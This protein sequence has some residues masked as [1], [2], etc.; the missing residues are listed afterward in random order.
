MEPNLTT[1]IKELIEDCINNNKIHTIKEF[2]N[3]VYKEAAVRLFRNNRVPENIYKLSKLK[4]PRLIELLS[5]APIH[6]IEQLIE[7]NNKKNINENE[8]KYG[9]EKIISY[10]IVEKI[11]D[12]KE[13]DLEK[14]NKEDLNEVLEYQ[15]MFD[16][17]IEIMVEKLMHETKIKADN[18]I[19]NILEINKNKKENEEIKWPEG[20]KKTIKYVK[21]NIGNKSKEKWEILEASIEKAINLLKRNI[22]ADKN[23]KK[24]GRPK[25]YKKNDNNY[26]ALF[27]E[28]FLNPKTNF[29]HEKMDLDE[30]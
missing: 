26:S 2:E 1:K 3:E 16:L 28:N 29:N 15:Q 11:I 9:K 22:I 23:K 10:I 24:V 27:M 17:K 19:D 6:I 14:P 7:S 30:N 20:I 25:Q 13:F 8:I 12:I 4:L 21:D 18:Y 5:N